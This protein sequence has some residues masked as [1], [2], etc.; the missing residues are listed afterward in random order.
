MVTRRCL[1]PT[2]ICGKIAPIDDR[3]REHLDQLIRSRAKR[4]Q[5][6]LQHCLI[7]RPARYIGE[8]V[9]TSAEAEVMQHDE[10]CFLGHRLGVAPVEAALRADPDAAG[11][12]AWT[13]AA[14]LVKALATAPALAAETTDPPPADAKP[15]S[16][17][18]LPSLDLKDTASARTPPALSAAV[19]A[20]WA[21]TSGWGS[22]SS[23]VAH[24]TASAVAP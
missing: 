8:D 18:T 19:A 14:A 2:C 22:S 3:L 12:R 15:L 6:A 17:A 5:V 16:T 1:R 11:P 24:R 9:A 23:A 10:G 21:R 4:F 13:V 20:A 7:L